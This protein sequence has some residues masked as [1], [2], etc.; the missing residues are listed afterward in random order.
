MVR[1]NIS[2]IGKRERFEAINCYFLRL[3]GTTGTSL[4][5]EFTYSHI[6]STPLYGQWLSSGLPK[7]LGEGRF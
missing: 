4:C 7:G 6:S 2:T 1:L 3:I 5:P